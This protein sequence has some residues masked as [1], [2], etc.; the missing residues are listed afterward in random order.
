MRSKITLTSDMS[1]EDLMI[2]LRDDL[3][4]YISDD[5]KTAVI[6][7]EILEAIVADHKL[8]AERSEFFYAINHEPT[9]SVGLITR[10]KNDYVVRIKNDS[11]PL[12]KKATEIF[13]KELQRKCKGLGKSFSI[14]RP[15]VILEKQ[16]HN[17][18]DSGH[19]TLSW[20]AYI[21]RAIHDKKFE[22]GYALF[23]FLVFGF[24]LSEKYGWT[25][26]FNYPVWMS[27]TG[28]KLIGSFFTTALFALVNFAIHLFDLFKFRVVIW[29]RP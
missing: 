25:N 13:I 8:D 24:I 10:E 6:K 1:H 12:L 21:L 15:I 22:V 20:L 26:V 29:D 16:E 5:K 23:G 27:E 7:T 2:R 9:G 17:Q 11:L 4:V 19:Y 28:E 3:K 14:D 18:I